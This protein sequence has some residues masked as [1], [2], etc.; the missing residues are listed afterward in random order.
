MSRM[1]TRA[2]ERPTRVRRP[3]RARGTRPASGPIVSSRSGTC[4]RAGP[5]SIDR[6]APCR[7]ATGDRDAGPHGKADGPSNAD[8]AAHTQA[9]AD[10][11]AVPHTDA[12]CHAILGPERQPHTDAAAEPFAFGIRAVTLARCPAHAYSSRVQA[13]D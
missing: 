3:R 1:T 10:P 5:V 9:D 8:S 4:H 11:D 2:Q 6:P 13:I 7:P 12:E